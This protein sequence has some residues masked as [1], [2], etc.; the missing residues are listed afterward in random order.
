MSAL[1]TLGGIGLSLAALG[2]MAVMDPKRRRAF[3]LPAGP[4]TSRRTGWAIALAPGLVVPFLSG[5]AGLV[6]WLGAVSVAGWA[7]I[8]I[9]PG[10]GWR[11]PGTLARGWS[12][13]RGRASALSRRARS[14]GAAIAP[15]RLGPGWGSGWSAGW[16][17]GAETRA[18]LVARVARLEGRIVALEAEVA[19]LNDEAARPVARVA[20]GRETRVA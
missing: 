15:G 3:Q 5:A 4:V 12:R 13:L 2:R 7:L 20:E 14:V 19:R 16:G 8:S 9:P 1:A 10:R 6:L 17:T 11:V 18:G